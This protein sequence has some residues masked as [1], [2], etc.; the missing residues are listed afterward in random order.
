MVQ[1]RWVTYLVQK[2]VNPCW[3]TNAFVCDGAPFPT[4]EHPIPMASHTWLCLHALKYEA[5]ALY[6]C[7]ITDA[8]KYAELRST[9]QLYPTDK[10]LYKSCLKYLSQRDDGVNSVQQFMTQFDLVLGFIGADWKGDLMYTDDATVLRLRRPLLAR[11][12]R[13]F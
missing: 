13:Y 3:E 10:N 2:Q 5:D 1:E 8:V 4:M 6:D 7:A 11:H 9:Q 12:G